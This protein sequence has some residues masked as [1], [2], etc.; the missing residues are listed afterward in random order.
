MGLVDKHV[1]KIIELSTTI[2]KDSIFNIYQLKGALPEKK[3]VD[4]NGKPVLTSYTQSE[5]FVVFGVEEGENGG[6]SVVIND[7]NGAPSDT[8]IITN[9]Y[10]IKVLFNGEEADFYSLKFKARLWSKGTQKYLE[11]NNISVV[12]QNPTISFETE[13]VAGEFWDKRGV[14]FVIVVELH[15]ADDVLEEFETIG[16]IHTHKQ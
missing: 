3:S 9:R 13:E 1:K 8:L 4:A 10:N 14:Q 6:E 12:T 15:F 7:E 11:D 16:E 5:M 2:D